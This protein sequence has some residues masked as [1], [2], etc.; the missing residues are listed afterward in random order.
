MASMALRGSSSGETGS[1]GV[2]F[3]QLILKTITS[4]RQFNTAQSL[5]YFFITDFIAQFVMTGKFHFIKK[6]F[7]REKSTKNLNKHL[8]KFILF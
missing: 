4:K 7:F 6:R 2:W 1:L 3:L 5:E 8:F